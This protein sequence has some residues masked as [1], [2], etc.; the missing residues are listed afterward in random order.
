MQTRPM[1][2]RL[3]ILLLGLC[4]SAQTG[5]FAVFPKAAQLASPNGRLLIRNTDREASQADID[6]TFHSL[7]LV[8]AATGRSRKLCNY[9]GV[10]AVAWSENDS[11]L[12]TEYVGK[13]TSRAL[14]FSANTGTDPVML[15]A[16]ALT[17][18]VPVDLRPALR[19]NDHVFIEAVRVQRNDLFLRVWGYGAHDSPGFQ[20]TCKYSLTDATIACQERGA[21][22]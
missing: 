11:V 19:G 8:E 10:A 4:V 17:Q 5:Q 20:W 18:L 6:G 12:V 14:V 9:V 16:S 7:W 21:S 2:I 13:W 1:M 3:G 22:K 15:D